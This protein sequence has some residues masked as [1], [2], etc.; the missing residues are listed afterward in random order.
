MVAHQFLKLGFA[1]VWLPQPFP[2]KT[3]LELQHLRILGCISSAPQF[4]VSAVEVNHDLRAP[5][6]FPGGVGTQE[7]VLG[8]CASVCGRRAKTLPE[9]AEEHVTVLDAYDGINEPLRPFAVKAWIGI[10]LPAYQFQAQVLRGRN[11]TVE[12]LK[13]P[14]QRVALGLDITRGRDDDAKEI[15]RLHWPRSSYAGRPSHLPS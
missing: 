10:G 1:V 8:P 5:V 4:R 9:D 6:L 7:F 11:A 13:Y 3:L 2:G 12:F 14:W 15:D